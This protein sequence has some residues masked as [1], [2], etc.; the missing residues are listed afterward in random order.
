M[1]SIII[2]PLLRLLVH[3]FAYTPSCEKKQ[4]FGLVPWY[5]Y[6]G[7]TPDGTTGQCTIDNFGDGSNAAG[8]LDSHSPFLLIGLAVIDDLIRV[9]AM[10]AVA[11]IIYGGI[12]YATS[13]G[14]PDMTGKAKASIINALIGLVIALIAVGF[15]T[16]L[17][18]T[19]GG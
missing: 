15:V 6:M 13:Q 5:Q 16:Y 10:V 19:L 14:S 9:A 3:S 12:T 1:F 2:V 17:G 11:F 4:F 7:L 8:I 18:N